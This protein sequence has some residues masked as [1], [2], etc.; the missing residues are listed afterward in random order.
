MIGGAVTN[1]VK[2]ADNMKKGLFGWC[3][4]VT[5]F[6]L[7]LGALGVT[8]TPTRGIAYRPRQESLP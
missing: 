5:V 8:S 4:R 7:H 2:A 6:S 3:N 1:R